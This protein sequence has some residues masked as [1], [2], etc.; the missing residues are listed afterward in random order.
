M[1]LTPLLFALSACTTLPAPPAATVD[2]VQD[3]SLLANGRPL[4][5]GEAVDLARGLEDGSQPLDAVIDRLLQDPSL[6]DTVAK[7]ILLGPQSTK[8]RHPVSEHSVLRAFEGPSGDP[9]YY[10][11]ARCSLGEAVSVSPWWAPSTQVSVC[12]SAYQPDTM[13]DAEGRT[14]G[15]TTLAPEGG[16]GCGCGPRLIFCARDAEMA[17]D[18]RASAQ[19]EV[20]DTLALVINED[21]P[22]EQLFLIN[23]TVRDRNAELLYRRARIAAGEPDTL[24]GMEGFTAE[25]RLAPRSE[26]VPG[27]Q[28][29]ILTAPSVVYGSDALR[30]V[31]R[32]YYDYLWCAGASSSR[33]TTAAVLGLAVVDLREGDG[34]RQLAGMEVCTD[35]HAR[36]DYGMQFFSG[37]PSSTRGIDF[38]PKA[39]Q[40]GTGPLYVQNI[41]DYRGDGPLTPQGF[42]QLAL[43]Q[44]EFG[45][46]VTRKV[47]DAVFSG[48][49]SP[50]DVDAVYSTFTETHSFRSMMATALHRFA[51][52][53]LSGALADPAE[54]PSLPEPHTRV[55]DSAIPLPDALITAVDNHCAHCHDGADAFDLGESGYGRATLLTMLEQVAFRQMPPTAE[56][57]A[58]E[59]R[60][61]FVEALVAEL[62]AAPADREAALSFYE[63]GLRAHPV[64]EFRSSLE[65]AGLRAGGEAGPRYRSVESA[66][67]KRLQRYTPGFAAATGLAAL[68]V[69]KEE[70]KVGAALEDCVAAASA[71]EAYVVGDVRAR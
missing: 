6:G 59:E 43:Q 8:A 65:T 67:P 9:I 47:V 40:P 51:V 19:A 25:R 7:G 30:G 33:V 3:L 70:G 35:C 53:S 15:A 68:Q 63:G 38:R 61:R 50:D 27:Q 55:E 34:W 44:P 14:C 22:I 20:D 26:Q 60:R 66:V 39:V 64:H 16:E 42:A 31:L 56:G 1:K 4:A 21:L 41:D 36:L 58:P 71:P 5:Q 49:S 57:L 54:A 29:G 17:G 18:M 24:V 46:C 52:G 45:E 11:A 28:A 62:W 48:S 32:N 37:Y 69:C 12:P 13:G 10:L 23:E 2:L